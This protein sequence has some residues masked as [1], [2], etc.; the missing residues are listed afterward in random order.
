MPTLVFEMNQSLDG[1]VDHTEFAPSPTLVRHVI[2]EARGQARSVYGRRQRRAP[3]PG[4][5]R[6]GGP[7]T[8][9]RPAPAGYGDRVGEN[10]RR[11][12]DTTRCHATSSGGALAYRDRW[13]T[14]IAAMQRVLAKEIRAAAPTIEAYVREAIAAES[15]GLRIT[16]KKHSDFPV[17]EER[18]GF[19]ARG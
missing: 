1:Y 18:R 9:D 16:S 5:G 2:E 17:P 15:A 4:P 19:L 12:H 13:Q 3:L 8:R 7:R 10:A 11:A 14:E 6:P